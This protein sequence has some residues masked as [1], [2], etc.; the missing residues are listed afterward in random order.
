MT[1]IAAL[2]SDGIGYIAG[3]RGASTDSS[4]FPITEPKVWKYGEYLFGYYG[5][6]SLERLKYNFLPS[7]VEDNDLV[8]FMNSTFLDELHDAYESCHITRHEDAELIIVVQGKIFIHNAED[9]SMTQYDVDYLAKGSGG[10]FALG[11]LWTTV[12]ADIA[13]DKC[14]ELALKA[15]TTFSTSCVG[16]IDIISSEDE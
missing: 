6:F 4:I 12:Q 7:P 13:P 15:A 11:S 10:D 2:V 8:T 16:P 14:L 9:F 5:A 1:C 3:E